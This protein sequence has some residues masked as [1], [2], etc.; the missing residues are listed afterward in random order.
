MMWEYEDGS[1]YSCPEEMRQEVY[2]AH[3]RVNE[4]GCNGTEVLGTLW[5]WKERMKKLDLKKK[6]EE[7]TRK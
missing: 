6:L 3:H 2:T 5:G 1:G 4:M 7:E